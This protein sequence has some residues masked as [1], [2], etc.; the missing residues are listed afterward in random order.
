M[1]NDP[2]P[3]FTHL[4]QTQLGELFSV[5]S[6]QIGRWLIEVGLRGSN[7]Q[8]TPR[9]VYDGFVKSIS[10][11]DGPRFPVWEKVKTVAVLEQA[12]RKRVGSNGGTMVAPPPRS[13]GPFTARRS[14][15][16]GEGYEIL[17]GDGTVAAWCR[18]ERLADRLAWLL[19]LADKHRRLV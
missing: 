6:H 17:A 1:Q 15:E 16:D 7:K 14:G 10:P 5:S 12:G 13:L 8:P 2:F 3:Y 4:T 18:G 19:T 9:A 11:E